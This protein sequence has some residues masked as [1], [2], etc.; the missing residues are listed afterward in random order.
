MRSNEIKWQYIYYF[1]ANF[2]FQKKTLVISQMFP[3]EFHKDISAMSKTVRKIADMPKSAVKNLQIS[4]WTHLFL[5][6]I[7]EDQN[8][9][10]IKS[11]F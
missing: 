4:T 6:I 5:I 7:F 9:W 3:L 1:L 8:I 10:G 2:A 11:T